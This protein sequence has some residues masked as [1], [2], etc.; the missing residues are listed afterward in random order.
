MIY[1]LTGENWYARDQAVKSLLSKFEGAGPE[2]PDTSKITMAELEDLISAQSLFSEKRC[3]VLANLSDNKQVWDGLGG[4]IESTSPDLLLIITEDKPDK[5]TKSYKVLQKH[6][7]VKEFPL[8]TVR[9]SAEASEWLLVEAK[10][11]GLPLKT[12]DARLLIERVGVDQARLAGALEKLHL[13][14]SITPETIAS[15]IE[16]HPMNNVFTLLETAFSGENTEL[17]TIIQA[18]R[19]TEEPYRVFGLLSSQLLQLAALVYQKNTPS[20]QVA[21]DIGVAPFVLTK[22]SPY[23][24]RVSEHDMSEI[25]ELA[26]DTDIKMKSISVDPW[27]LIEELLIKLAH[28]M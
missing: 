25:L 21:R 22:L 15:S 4:L 24:R 17:R 5:R 1:F 27:L 23:A 9:D 7:E 11:Q 16:T 26:A 14:D 12:R 3:I 13:V 18:L 6:A 20:A 2:R 28:K 10:R 19:Q 8:W